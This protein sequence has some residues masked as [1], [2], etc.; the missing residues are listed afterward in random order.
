MK[1]KDETKQNKNYKVKTTKNEMKQNK[2]QNE[3]QN[4]KQ[5]KK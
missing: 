2:K 4:K 3:K 5:N 1:T